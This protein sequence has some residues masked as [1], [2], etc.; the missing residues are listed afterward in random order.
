MFRLCENKFGLV[1]EKGQWLEERWV[2]VW[3]WIW[4][5]RRNIITR[6]LDNFNAFLEFISRAPLRKDC[7]DIWLWKKDNNGRYNTRSAYNFLAGSDEND[8]RGADTCIFRWIWDR[9]TPLKVAAIVWRAT[10]D[11]LPTRENLRRRNILTEND[12]LSCPICNVQPESANHIFME[13]T[14]TF[15]LW[16]HCYKWLNL[17]GSIHNNLKDQLQLM[18]G[19]VKGKKGKRFVVGLWSCIIWRIWKGR[20][21]L[22]FDGK[23]FEWENILDDVKVRL[24]SWVLN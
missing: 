19:M 4:N 12:D 20:N 13:C 9:I 8:A 16:Y 18:R 22:I 14:G 17:Q 2:W 21:D 3:I 6:E 7:Q 1:C 24:W 10:W 11:R 5:W 15:P 23:K